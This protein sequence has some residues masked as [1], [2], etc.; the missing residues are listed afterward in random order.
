[1]LKLPAAV[2]WWI[3]GR[4]RAILTKSGQKDNL[5]ERLD[6]LSATAGVIPD[7]VAGLVDDINLKKNN[8][9]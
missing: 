3:H 6:K 5:R 4:N 2:H 9:K 1:M 7:P 8:N